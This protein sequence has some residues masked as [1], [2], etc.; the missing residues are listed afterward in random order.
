MSQGMVIFILICLFSIISLLSMITLAFVNIWYFG[1]YLAGGVLSVVALVI[2]DRYSCSSH[3]AFQE[4]LFE[5]GLFKLLPVFCLWYILIP[6]LLI[7]KLA[8]VDA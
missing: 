8:G 3:M 1:L 7:R 5:E 2:Y 6:A 4:Y